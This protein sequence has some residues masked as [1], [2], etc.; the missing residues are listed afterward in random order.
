[1]QETIYTSLGSNILFTA[2]LDKAEY[3]IVM[4]IGEIINK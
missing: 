2:M 1:M 4:G 3:S